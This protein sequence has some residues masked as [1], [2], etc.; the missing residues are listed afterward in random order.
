MYYCQCSWRKLLYCPHEDVWRWELTFFLWIFCM[1]LSNICSIISVSVWHGFLCVDSF[2][3]PTAVFALIF[4]NLLAWKPNLEKNSI[5]SS[6]V[7][8]NF[9]LS[10][11]SGKWVSMKTATARCQWTLRFTCVCMYTCTSVCPYF[12]L[13]IPPAFDFCSLT[14]VPLK[15]IISHYLQGQ[16]PWKA[17]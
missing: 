9:H 6:K 3:V 4:F 13:Y 12:C 15:Q 14:K 7:F 8:H 1:W 2:Y 17:A 16:G 11:A 5:Y 10:R